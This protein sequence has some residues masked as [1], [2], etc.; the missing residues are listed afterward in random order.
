MNQTVSINLQKAQTFLHKAQPLKARKICEKLLK[1]NGESDEVHF[2]IG[3]SFQLQSRSKEALQ[4]FLKACQ[5]NPKNATAHHSASI[6]FLMLEQ[7][8][9]AE[10]Y[11]Q[12]ALELAPSNLSVITN[13]A[14]ILYKKMDFFRAIVFFKRAILLGE[15]SLA[16]WRNF[17]DCSIKEGKFDEA[18]EIAEKMPID[19]LERLEIEAECYTQLNQYENVHNCAGKIASFANVNVGALGL[20]FSLYRQVGEFDKAASLIKA[21]G[22]Y[23]EISIATLYLQ[24]ELINEPE[25]KKIEKQYSNAKLLPEEQA[26]LAYRISYYYKDKNKQTWFE[27]LKKANALQADSRDYKE[28]EIAVLF[29]KAQCELKSLKLPCSDLTT[30]APVFIFGMPRSGTTLTESILASHSQ[31]FGC[32][33]SSALNSVVNQ[34][35]NRNLSYQLNLF[36]FVEQLKNYSQEDFKELG[37]RYLKR[38]RQYDKQAE[39]LVNKMPNNFIMSPLLPFIFPQAKFIHIKRNPISNCLSIFEQQFNEIYSYGNTLTSIADYYKL[40]D[41]YM[42]FVKQYVPKGSIYELSYEDLVTDTEGEI[43]K[44]L[45]YCELD[46]EPQCLEFHKQKRTIKTASVKQVRKGIYKSSIKRWQGLEEQVKEL[47]EA[48]PEYK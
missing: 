39:R 4:Y 15:I 16:K 45:D 31:V 48:F 26:E 40:Y 3:A 34:N 29:L 47:L 12:K 35:S 2:M 7:L 38:I 30:K 22:T 9:N 1:K 6:A 25:I 41:N 19:S 13:V 17:A 33:E 5:L 37:K 23:S 32:G 36:S 46:F 10:E 11:A 18:L 28:Q 42:D 14:Q 27:W 24:A 43:R 21:R 44:L 8:K 20:A